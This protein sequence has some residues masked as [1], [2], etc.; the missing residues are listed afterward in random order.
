MADDNMIQANTTRD[1]GHQHSL[2]SK[3]PAE[4]RNNIYRE[5]STGS[6]IVLVI[7]PPLDVDVVPVTGR[8][9]I[10]VDANRSH[11][12][13]L[14]CVQVY[15]EALALYW[16]SIAVRSG[17]AKFS[18]GFFLNR[19]P[20]AARPYIQHLRDVDAAPSGKPKKLWGEVIGWHLSLAESLDSFRSLRSCSVPGWNSL[21]ALNELRRAV[22]R[23]PGVHFLEKGLGT[24]RTS[25]SGTIVIVQF[26]ESGVKRVRNQ[27]KAAS[28]LA[29]DRR[30]KRD[31]PLLHRKWGGGGGKNERGPLH[32]PPPKRENRKGPLQVA[33]IVEVYLR[34]PHDWQA[35]FL[36]SRRCA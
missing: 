22:D 15:L 16:S 33:N 35:D 30:T 27:A 4:V 5:T 13:L 26:G 31:F 8:R 6:E 2:L 25:C 1:W 21:V 36:D 3:L 23:H 17:S 28:F 9:S 11:N 19:I 34:E 18:H 24:K 14:T 12:F 32:R 7:D 10:F 20:A 29:W